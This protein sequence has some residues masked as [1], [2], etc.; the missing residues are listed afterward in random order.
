MLRRSAYLLTATIAQQPQKTS[1]AH[2][3][4]LS[5]HTS[6]GLILVR[7][8]LTR[9][10]W[11]SRDCIEFRNR[12]STRRWL[13]FK[14]S[15]QYMAYTVCPSPYFASRPRLLLGADAP[16]EKVKRGTKPSG[17]ERRRGL[18]ITS[19]L[20]RVVEISSHASGRLLIDKRVAQAR[21]GRE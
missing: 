9:N 5:L 20:S 13:W 1:Q 7:S 14:I 8:L 4:A 21:N 18:C 17:K 11:A 6:A 10:S 16:D 12:D 15:V 2:T 3:N 19:L